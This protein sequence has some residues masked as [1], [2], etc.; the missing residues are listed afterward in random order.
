MANK[1]TCGMFDM[2]NDSHLFRTAMPNLEREGFYPVE[3]NSLEEAETKLYLPLYQGRMMAQPVR[4]S[5]R[6]VGP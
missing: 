6:E 1:S 4:P 5:N 3:G 2:T